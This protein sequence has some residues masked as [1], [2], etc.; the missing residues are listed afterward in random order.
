MKLRQSK[1]APTAGQGG[2]AAAEAAESP[3]I[4]ARR[5]WNERYGEYI[6][7]ERSWRSIA[8]F[9]LSIAALAVVGLVVVAAQSKIVPY[10]VEV[11]KLGDAVA[12]R[13]ADHAP[14]PDNRI[15][16]AQLAHWITNLRSVY[17][18]AAAEHDAIKDAYALIN[19]HGAAYGMLNDYMRVDE[20]NPFIRAANET[21]S[22]DVQSVLP[23]TADTWRVEWLETVRDRGGHETSHATWSA[24]IN[25][26][27]HP[28]TDEKTILRNP[29]GVF[30]NSVN[31]SQRL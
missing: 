13:R 4:N 12:V 9:A 22:I 31:W 25:I 11:D 30:I 8:F 20:H 1:Q 10:T 7:R 6:V 17:V 24:T 27:I 16:R 26:S 14:P 15:V 3:Y 2:A 21:V 18:D 5:E 23:L 19:E 28:P 29:T